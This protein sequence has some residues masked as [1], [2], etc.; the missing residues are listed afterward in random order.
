M[1]TA[2]SPKPA[3]SRVPSGLKATVLAIASRPASIRRVSLPVTVSHK[4]T[5]PPAGLGRGQ[6]PPIRA[7]HHVIDQAFADRKR[8]YLISGGHVMDAHLGGGARPTPAAARRG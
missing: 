1:R 2:P 3:A 6:Q 4:P 7:E 8:E 5:V